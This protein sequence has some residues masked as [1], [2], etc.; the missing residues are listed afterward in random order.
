LGLEYLSASLFGIKG[1]TTAMGTVMFFTASSLISL[2]C[3][4]AL[5]YYYLT[6][7][8]SVSIDSYIERALSED[9]EISI[10]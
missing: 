7:K 4:A 3:S 1:P 5:T 10:A 2:G 9:S 6:P 8:I